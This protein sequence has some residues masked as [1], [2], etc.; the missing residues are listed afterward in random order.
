M[1]ASAAIFLVLSGALYG[2][3]LILT[4]ALGDKSCK[5]S[6]EL[7]RDLDRISL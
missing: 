7:S 1:A 4:E 3:E 5:L 6:G 2:G